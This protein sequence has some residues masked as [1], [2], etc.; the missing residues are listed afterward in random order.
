MVFSSITFLYCFL[1]ILIIVYYSLPD[2]FKN[3]VLLIF[4]LLFYFY[5][6]PNYILVLISSFTFNYFIAKFICKHKSKSKLYLVLGLCV[7]I[8]LL[9]YFKYTNFFIQNINNILGTKISFINVL[10]P[11]G[12]SFFTFQEI[13]YL[14][15]VYKDKVKPSNS[16]LSYATYISLF[17]QLIAGPIVRYVTVNEEL[18]SRKHT[19]KLFASGVE[20]FVVGIAKKV[21]LANLL[22]SMCKE[23][24]NLTSISVLSYWLQ[25]IGATLQLYLDFSAYSDMA[26]GLGRMFGFKFQENF[27]YPLIAKSITDF[28]RRWHIS[29]S[30]FFRDYVYIP[31]G[32]NRVSKLKWIRNILV[33]WMLTGFWHGASW[34]FILWGLY[35]AIL[36]ILEKKLWGNVIQKSKLI[37]HLYTLLL[38]VISFVIFNNESIKDILKFIGGMFGIGVGEFANNEVLYYF[39]SYFII[40]ILSVIASTPILKNVVLLLN[41][42]KYFSKVSVFLEPICIIL[43]LIVSTSFLISQ[44]YNPFLYFRF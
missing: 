6:E 9:V 20:R 21:I 4:S 26:I 25:A 39:K 14:V 17:P 36:L 30:S 44:S 41:S 35:F 33:V 3:T 29:L 8:G 31:L 12:I 37:S 27:N 43:L 23:L 19:F 16:L 38:V 7:N 28:W 40:I 5:G 11:I 1:P 18:V 42:K 24:S 15:D 2:K 34:N 32:G 10:M 13:S 22:G